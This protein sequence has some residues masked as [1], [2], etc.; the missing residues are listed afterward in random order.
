MG[1]SSVYRAVPGRLPVHGVGERRWTWERLEEVLLLVI[2]VGVL[3]FLLYLPFFAGFSS[4]AGGVLPNLVNPT[5]GAH[6]WVM[7]G[8]LFIPIF[9]YLVYLWRREKISPNWV[10]GISLVI[11]VSVLLWGASW[12]LGVLA[13]KLQPAIVSGYLQ[14]E[15][16]T[17][18][19]LFFAAATWR[20]LAYIGG[21]ITQAAMLAFVFAFLARMSE[22]KNHETLEVQEGREDTNVL[23]SSSIHWFV[24]LLILIGALLVL[25]PDYVF[26][27]DLFGNRLNTVFK[28]Y[29]NG[30]ILWSMASAFGTALMLQNL[31]GAWKWIYRLGMGFALIM[32]ICFF[33]YGLPYNT[34]NFQMDAFRQNLEEARQS[35]NP[36]PLLK[37]AQ[38]PGLWMGRGYSSLNIRRMRRG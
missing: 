13:L 12:L 18:T 14:A 8:A 26:L 4:Q 10:T 3:S 23:Q 33:A 19:G 30:W 32:G 38:Q 17:N 28:F 7:F 34:S 11:G 16:I 27:R 25:A 36:A 9:A 31:N 1:Y 29:F 2:P 5:R 24:L 35:G 6:L 37:A 20:R 21:W 15:E 22:K